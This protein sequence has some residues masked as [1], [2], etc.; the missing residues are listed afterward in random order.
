MGED[1]E[2]DPPA[3]GDSEMSLFSPFAQQQD[4]ERTVFTVTGAVDVARQPSG[5]GA[6]IRHR[7]DT[8]ADSAPELDKGGDTKRRRLATADSLQ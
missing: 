6:S 4:S 5:S 3:A 8:Q 2:G 7:D 1:A